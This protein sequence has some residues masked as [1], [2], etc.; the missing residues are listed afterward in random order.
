[1]KP[2]VLALRSSTVLCLRRELVR[3][4]RRAEAIRLIL[5]E[6]GRINAAPS[7]MKQKQRVQA[8]DLEGVASSNRW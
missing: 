2:N 4:Q 1:V 3:Y 6:D 7:T 5:A 8:T